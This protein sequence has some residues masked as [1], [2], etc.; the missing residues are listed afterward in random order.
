MK[1]QLSKKPLEKL[2]TILAKI[3]SKLRVLRAK[4]KREIEKKK[5]KGTECAI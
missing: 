3:E 1:K 2:D 5:H 4:V